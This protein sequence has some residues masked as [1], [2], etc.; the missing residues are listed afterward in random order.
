MV[1]RC[2]PSCA[3][4]STWSSP[5]PPTSGNMTRCRRRWRITNP[6]S[7]CELGD[8][9]LE[10][11][12]EIVTRRA[13]LARAGWRAAR[14]AGSAP[15]RGASSRSPGRSGAVRAEIR[16]DAL[17]R[18]RALVADGDSSGGMEWG[19]SPPVPLACEAVTPAGALRAGRRCCSRP[20][21]CTGWPSSPPRPGR[22]S[23]SSTSKAAGGT[24][25]SRS[26]SPTPSRRGRSP[27]RRCPCR[28]QLAAAT[29]RA[30]LT[31]VVR[32]GPGWDGDIGDGRRPSACAAP[33]TTWSGAVPRG[34]PVGDQ[35]RQPPR[36]PHGRHGR[37]GRRR[38]RR[39]S[40]W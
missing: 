35:Q 5:T 28:G 24:S 22:R 17:G 32:P 11:I 15:G 39:P 10:A 1:R 9:G 25:R 12:T 3:A 16:V 13:R 2:R 6:G 40:T 33:T 4:G 30:P 23:A 14:R 37:R 7:R 38:A 29:G 18:E 27:P 26:S 31:L 8:D 21:P 34:R 20:T 36:V 19:Y